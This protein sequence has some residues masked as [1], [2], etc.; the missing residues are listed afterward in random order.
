MYADKSKVKG[1]DL[2]DPAVK[3]QIYDQYLKAYKKGVFN[4]IKEDVNAAGATVPRKYFSG[5]LS[6]ADTPG[7]N[8]AMT[9]DKAALAKSLPMDRAM[10]LFRTGLNTKPL[11][12]QSQQPRNPDA[13]MPRVLYSGDEVE[14]EFGKKYIGVGGFYQNYEVR[15]DES[16]DGPEVLVLDM[17]GADIKKDK[18]GVVRTGDFEIGLKDGRVYL[19]S[20]SSKIL[21]LADAAM[22]SEEEF[23]K[24]EN[25]GIV[26]WERVWDL[27]Y[28]Q[29]PNK[30]TP[31]RLGYDA[32]SIVD[33]KNYSKTKTITNL[34]RQRF[35]KAL[36]GEIGLTWHAQGDTYGKGMVVTKEKF[37]RLIADLLKEK[38]YMARL[39]ISEL[40]GLTDDQIG[41]DAQVRLNQMKDPLFTSQAKSTFL[42]LHNGTYSI[43][44]TDP[45]PMYFAYMYSSHNSAGSY[46]R[47]NDLSEAGILRDGVELVDE[48]QWVVLQPGH[49]KAMLLDLFEW[50]PQKARKFVEA[51]LKA[52][53]D[54]AMMSKEE[55]AGSGIDRV[56]NV[57][58]ASLTDDEIRQAAQPGINQ[59]NDPLFTLAKAAILG[60]HNGEYFI[61]YNFI[62]EFFAY[63]YSSHNDVG[64][65][66]RS[67]DQST[68]G[69][70]LKWLN[71]T[72]DG[73]HW[74]V[75][76]PGHL[77]IM[78]AHLYRYNPVIA[79]KLI[80]ALSNISPKAQIRAVRTRISRAFG[81][82]TSSSVDALA[83][84]LPAQKNGFEIS[85]ELGQAIINSHLG[86]ILRKHELPPGGKLFFYDENGQEWGF[87]GK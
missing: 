38:A 63:L 7:G 30:T 50:N 22:M 65:Y 47:S 52:S 57:T 31:L 46:D 8:P 59:I 11:A 83:F 79:R 82:R 14:I 87:L 20:T 37:I 49:M 43:V 68:E 51:F 28:K 64:L 19:R 84:W 3:Q 16:T 21:Y 56:V 81:D 70:K 62:L 44:S 76:Q 74:A 2:S 80:L 61:S 29:L 72:Y 40:A 75:I 13:M 77:K 73:Y 4:Y 6:I 23:I 86:R 27:A 54:R 5:G 1:I 35:P 45:T 69:I 26:T 85:A 10:M 41:Q 42:G 15:V 32:H 17:E 60:L 55:L 25:D 39:L 33:F 48:R 24:S 67:R 18:D 66:G 58:L 78:I 53:K 36:E 34:A 12:E 71:K 9:T